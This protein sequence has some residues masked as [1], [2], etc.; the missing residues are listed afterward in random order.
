MR[1]DAPGRSR[2]GLL[3]LAA[4]LPAVLAPSAFVRPAFAQKEL[5]EVPS[6]GAW[7]AGGYIPLPTKVDVRVR[8]DDD[9]PEYMKLRDKLIAALRDAGF[10]RSDGLPLMLAVRIENRRAVEVPKDGKERGMFLGR[11]VLY[12]TDPGGRKRYWD[13]EAVWRP[14]EGEI[15]PG[16]EA[17]VPTIVGRLGQTV[18]LES[19]M[20]Y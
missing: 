14:F 13:A 11:M 18:E 17:L 5:E 19:V 1:P 6:D 10:M 4:L 15:T 9:A 8:F 20:L 7:R 12:L 2:R 3:R 16:A